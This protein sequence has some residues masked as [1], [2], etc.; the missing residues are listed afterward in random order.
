M[1]QPATERPKD[2]ALLRSVVWLAFVS[3][4]LPALVAF[5]FID[6]IVHAQISQ[7]QPSH[8]R[9]PAKVPQDR[10]DLHRAG[11]RPLEKR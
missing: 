7:L 10:S 5:Y 8:R 3:A 4:G 11:A 9:I 1:E 6:E 2:R